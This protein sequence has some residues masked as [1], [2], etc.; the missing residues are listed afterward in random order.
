MSE[1]QRKG[2]FFFLFSCF[3]L[4]GAESDTSTCHTGTCLCCFA[5]L[6]ELLQGR[7]WELKS[8]YFFFCLSLVASVSLR[9]IE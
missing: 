5:L 4:L 6:F 9:S 7:Q 8:I 3:C 1:L 2:T